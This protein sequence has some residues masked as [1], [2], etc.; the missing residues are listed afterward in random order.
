MGK[1]MKSK[2]RA[3]TKR[4]FKKISEEEARLIKMWHKED[5]KPPR[6]IAALLHRDK[7]TITRHLRV[8]KSICK[9]GR[10][11][12]L[13]KGQVDR[14]IA[15]AEQYIKQAQGR[16]RITY[17]LIKR[18]TRTKVS[19]WTIMRAFHKRGIS[20]KKFREKPILSDEDIAER[21][22]FAKANRRKSEKQ[23][24]KIHMHIDCKWFPVYLN[25]KARLFAARRRTYGAFRGR[26][27]GLSKAH[28]RPRKDLKF[29]TGSRGVMVLAGVGPGGVMVWE[30][31]RGQQKWNA[32]TAAELYRGPIASALRKAHPRLRRFRVL[33]DNDPSGFKTKKAENAKAASGIKPFVIPKRSPQLN[34][35]DFAVWSEINSRLRKQELRYSGKKKESR[36]QYLL[37]LRRTAMRLSSKFMTKS[38]KNLKLRCKR[39]YEAKGGHIEEGRDS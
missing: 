38:I 17:Q 4:A 31:L 34:V 19:T 10:Q 13:S 25:G 8:K 7:S 5:Q 36:A 24:L 28:V 6:E 29:N 37:R 18:R 39:L 30:A 3:R 16:Y 20:F 11:S 22:K 23:W 9:Q 26:G 12:G 35:L 2:Q 1:T 15:K 27:L 33:E 21:F 14:L 32:A